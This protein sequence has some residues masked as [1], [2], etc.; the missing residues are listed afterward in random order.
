MSILVKFEHDI[1]PFSSSNNA[2]TYRVSIF[3]LK[4]LEIEKFIHVFVSLSQYDAI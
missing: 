4:I 1:N 3:S 2:K